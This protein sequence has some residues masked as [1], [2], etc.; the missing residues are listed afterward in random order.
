[1]TPPTMSSHPPGMFTLFFTEMWERFSYYGMRALLVLFMVEEMNKPNGGLGLTDATA[2][3][4]YGL[5]TSFVYVVALPGGWIGDHVLGLRRSVWWGGVIIALGHIILAF[6]TSQ[7]FYLGLL[8]VALGSGLLKSNMSA[9]VGQLYPEG[10]ARR[11]AGFTLFYMGI[12]I[13]AFLGPLACS[14][15]AQK[16][17]RLGF[18]AAAVGMILGLI[19]FKLTEHRLGNAGLFATPPP[20]LKRNGM[21]I[22]IALIPLAIFTALCM[23][24]V[25]TL[26]PIWLSKGTAYVIIGFAVLFFLWAF[27]LGGLDLQEKKHLA[28][29]VVLF[30]AS[31]LFWMGFEQMGSSF[32][33][34]AERYTS[35]S[36]GA[37]KIP[38]GVLHS[39]NPFFVISLAPVVAMLWLRLAARGCEPRL[40]TK[41]AWGMLL[42]AGGF[43]IAAWAAQRAISSGATVWPTWLITVILLHTVGELFLSP[44]GLSA[45]TKLAPQRLQGQMMGVWFLGTALGNI[46]AG[47]LAGQASGLAMPNLFLLVVAISGAAGL[48]LWILSPLI[49]KMMPGIK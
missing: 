48:L 22:I 20:G 49:Q 9:L 40:V 41:L 1:M 11:D 25:I 16:D 31:A 6:H 5:Y 18:G 45:V 3:A 4:I 26:D 21:F 33:L 30:F 29:I 47:I 39:V 8:V 38:A 36:I 19:N 10:G 24:G 46:L 34:F 28:V 14:F 37:W 27:T 15:L 17:W 2:A 44:V 12:N 23:S 42:L 35:R 43:L 7:T 13:G 32:T